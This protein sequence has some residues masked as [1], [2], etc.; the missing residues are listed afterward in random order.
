MSEAANESTSTEETKNGAKA[1][2]TDSAKETDWKAEAR[3]WEQRAKENTEA[4]KKLADLEEANKTELQKA[5]ERAEKAEAVSAQA[6]LTALKTRIAAEMNVPVEVL[7]GDDENA[8]KASAQKV[9]E[10]AASNKK[11]P[12]KVTALKS[13]STAEDTSGMTGKQKAAAALRSLRNAD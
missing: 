6:T 2:E 8:L 9:L 11:Q 3:K 13:G 7:H 12:P 5:I 1:G 4:A 10:W